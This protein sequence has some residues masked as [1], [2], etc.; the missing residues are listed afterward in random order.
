MSRFL[1]IRHASH[2]YLNRA[3]AGWRPG[4]H[5][6]AQ[7][8]EEAGRLA[9]ALDGIPIQ[10]LYTSPLERTLETA[11]AISRCTGAE[12]R[13]RED[14]GEV[15][16]GDWTDVDF[17]TL[18]QD[19]RWQTFT[20]FRAGTRAPGGEMLL[21]VQARMVTAI[22]RLRGEH[23]RDT[24]AIISHG[25]PIKA[26]LMHYLGI[27]LDLLH[28]IDISPASVSVLELRDGRAKVLL[29]N[30]LAPRDGGRFSF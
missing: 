17:E 12:V 3:I 6:N 27:A 30:S 24:G 13:V 2:D 16:F 26:A 18:N 11:E 1:L 10:A 7:G 9:A 14:F 20:R 25:D 19:P 23:P 21:E 5:L 29:L 28:R 22:E 8:R 15:R 4:V